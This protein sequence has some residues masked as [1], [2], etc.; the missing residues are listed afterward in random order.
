MSDTIPA[1]SRQA[2]RSMGHP[3]TGEVL[4][5]SEEDAEA[6][7]DLVP[8][9]YSMVADLQVEGN[10]HYI[11]FGGFVNKN[12]RVYVEE[13]TQFPKADPVLKLL[14]TLRSAKGVPCAFR[15]TANPGG[16]GHLWVKRRYIDPYPAGNA[17]IREWEP[18]SKMWMERIFIP[19]K[20][21]DN[22]LLTVNDPFYIARLAQ[23]GSANLVKAWLDGDWSVIDGAYFDCWSSDRMVVKPHPIPKRWTRYR[24]FD[25]GSASP[26]SCG[27]WALS[28]GLPAEIPD[29]PPDQ[30]PVYPKG[31][32]IRYR[33]WY[34]A[35]GD[36][37]GIKLQNQEIGRGIKERS[38]GEKIAMTLCDPSIFK[39]DGGPSIAEQM[40]KGGKFMMQK[41]D[42]SRIPGWGQMRARM[43]GNT[44]GDDANK[45]MIYCFDT[46]VDS[47]RTIPALQHDDLNPEDLDTDG[48]DH[49]ADDWR[50]MCASRP[51][52]RKLA[53]GPGQVAYGHVPTL[54]EVI[55]YEQRNSRSSG[56]RRI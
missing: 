49:A 8:Y 40:Y 17:I 19:S 18:R 10:N 12:T 54:A 11:T 27:W 3:Y 43:L 23:S 39:E 24:S 9:G 33:E 1:H 53:P 50:Y 37:K 2:Q 35:D 55:A 5:L 46:C 16:P 34:G 36:N 38:R 25:W 15:A 28:D 51:F 30:W 31:A 32:L 7:V 56:N 4:H 48:E 42:N 47:I 41:A 52:Q 44:I 14:A 26:F 45:P 13:L 21:Q 20:V 6:Q 22:R 29:M